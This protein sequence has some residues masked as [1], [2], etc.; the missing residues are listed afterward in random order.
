MSGDGA[1]CSA[2][3]PRSER[4][5]HPSERA[6]AFDAVLI[7]VGIRHL[8]PPASPKF[9]DPACHPG[10]SILTPHPSP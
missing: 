3:R 5:N 2:F 6:S 4:Y 10:Y 7:I 8:Q 9:T 1:A